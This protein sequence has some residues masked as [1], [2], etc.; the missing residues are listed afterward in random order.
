MLGI[1]AILY[2]S[3]RNCFPSCKAAKGIER[4]PASREN[5]RVC[6]KSAHRQGRIYQRHIRVASFDNAICPAATLKGIDAT[7]TAHRVISS[8][9]EESVV[10]AIANQAVIVTPASDVLDVA[11]TARVCACADKQIQCDWRGICRVVEG[12]NTSPTVDRATN[13]CAVAQEECIVEIAAS[14]VL[15]RGEANCTV[16]IASVWGC[17]VPGVGCVCPNQGAGCC[18]CPNYL[19]N[20]HSP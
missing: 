11:H 3:T 19:F 12:I 20:V 18:G 6:P 15:E 8:I 2:F 10:V 9:A 13:A 7:A 14:Q 4:K 17:D 16:D 1:R 5:A